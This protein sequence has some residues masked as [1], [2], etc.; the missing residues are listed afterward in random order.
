MRESQISSFYT[1]L[2]ACALSCSSAPLLI[3]PS[4]T[5]TDSLTALK[6][7]TSVLASDSVL[8]SVY[9]VL[10]IPDINSRLS[11]FSKEQPLCILLINLGS[12]SDLRRVLGLREEG[13]TRVFVVDS[14]RPIHLHNL[15]GGNEKVVVLY[16]GEDEINADLS[17]DFD[18]GALANASDLNSDDEF[19]DD[20]DDDSDS[21]S[22]LEFEEVEEKGRKKRRVERENES[23]PLRL[24]GKLKSEYYKLGT[25]HGKPSGFLLFEL[26][27]F[28]RKNN[29]ELLWLACVSLTDQLVHERLTS[30]R[31]QSGVMELEQYINCTS[32]F[33]KSTC[34]TLKD[35]TKIRAPE[36]SKISYEDEPRLMLLRQWSLFDSMLYSSYSATKLRT[37]SDNGL[38]KLMLLM[39]RMGFPL[40]DCKKNF[41]YM[42]LAVKNGM[43]EKFEQFLPEYGLSDFFF[44]SFFKINGYLNSKISA[45][46]VVY[47]VTALLE[48]K[49]DFWEAY[50]ALNNLE[51]LKKGMNFAIEI[52]RAIL[53]QGS[54]AITKS[55]FI[56]SGRKFRWVKIDDP[57]DSV[58]LGHPMALTKFSY[59]LMDAL[60]ERGAKVKPLVCVCEVK[61]NC[62]VLIVGICNRPR[63]GAVKGN[64]FGIAFRIAGREIGAEFFEELVESSWVLLDASKVSNF[65]VRLT[66]KL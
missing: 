56:K 15:S 49:S 48:S 21:E 52:Q 5:D 6:I 29:N 30:E 33:E 47:G 26:A 12:Q 4:S 32:N 17:Y 64:E 13:L 40:I 22:D 38:K 25:F 31:Y 61:G 55:G 57:V 2:R 39:A 66:E 51:K 59:F 41:Q 62:R 43:K 18:V 9:P 34:V 63:I 19:D 11:S 54:N 65:M 46:D 3:F 23:D 24:Y 14:H 37:W 50:S 45:A 42:S 16:S 10:Q 60:K 36:N 7:L 53:R 28:L 44:R 1:K 8:Y 20:D 35:G 58:K 27:H